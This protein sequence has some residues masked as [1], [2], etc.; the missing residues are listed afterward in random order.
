VRHL[1]RGKTEQSAANQASGLLDWLTR[2]LPTAIPAS[3]ED[4]ILD[5]SGDV[6]ALLWHRSELENVLQKSPAAL[7]A[8][9]RQRLAARDAQ[10]RRSALLIAGAEKGELRRFREGYYDR[11]H[12]W[13]YLDDTLQEELIAKNQAARRREYRFAETTPSL[14]KVAEPRAE[15]KR[16]SPKRKRRAGEKAEATSGGAG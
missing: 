15:Y 1:R 6:N 16:K 11:S 10:I 2:F 12:W 3:P 13:W 7:S 5:I 8:T 4:A 14:L 9:Q